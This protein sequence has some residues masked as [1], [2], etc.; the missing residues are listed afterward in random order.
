MFA[1]FTR[2]A[3]AFA[4]SCI[5]ALLA[6]RRYAA[7]KR[8]DR[9]ARHREAVEQ[10][11]GKDVTTRTAGIYA[12]ERVAV[13][14]PLDLEAVLGEL[15]VFIRARKPRPDDPVGPDVQTALRTIS[16][17]LTLTDPDVTPKVQLRDAHIVGAQLAKTC[18]RKAD[19][20]G[21]NAGSADPLVPA[22]SFRKS[23]L[24][25]AILRNANLAW[26]NFWRADARDANFHDAILIEATLT[27]ADLR[28]TDLRGADLRKA[29]IEGAKLR[30]ADIRGADLSTAD[31]LTRDQL[32]GVR[33]DTATRLPP[34][35]KPLPASLMDDLLARMSARTRAARRWMVY[36]KD[37]DA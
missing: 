2:G 33:R 14:S 27:R 25:W 16:R 12:L 13:E 30:G 9:A 10:L 5:V 21:A 35:F 1:V 17:I 34:D 23:D 26:V 32:R 37:R 6:W 3:G 36:G 11:A 15:A 8:S 18:F 7:H 29:R 19:L 24:R 4:V 28:N 22:A 31:G 20:S